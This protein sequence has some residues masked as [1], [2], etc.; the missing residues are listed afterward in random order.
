MMPVP[1][2]GR[3]Y[4]LRLIPVASVNLG[5]A[6]SVTEAAVDAPVARIFSVRPIT[7]GTAIEAAPDRT[8]SVMIAIGSL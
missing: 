1:D 8:V 7:S 6:S 3:R 5:L 2:L 4:G